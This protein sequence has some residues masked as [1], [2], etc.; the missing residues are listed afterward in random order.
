MKKHLEFLGKR[1]KDK[2]TGIEGV[3]TSISFDLYGC[4]QGLVHPGLDE[5]GKQKELYWYD[6]TRLEITSSVPVM[7]CPN[8]GLDDKGPAEKPTSTN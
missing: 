3:V 6:I 7:P 4:I 8:F 1:V 5:T 2:V